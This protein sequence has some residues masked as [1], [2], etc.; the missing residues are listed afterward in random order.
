MDIPTPEELVAKIEAFIARHDMAETRFGR[1]AVSDPNLLSD[2]RAG[3]R[4]PGLNKLNRIA[5]FIRTKDADAGFIGD[6][7]LAGG[8][9]SDGASDQSP[10]ISADRIGSAT[11]RVAA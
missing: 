4:L 11:S 3:K 5:D 6:V 1:D 8:A 10:D 9:D 2:L 7:P